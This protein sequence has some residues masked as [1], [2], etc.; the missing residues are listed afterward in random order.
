MITDLSEDLRI[1]LINNRLSNLSRQYFELEMDKAQ[2][3]ANDNAQDIQRVTDRMTQLE[4]AY[5][6]IQALL[7]TTLA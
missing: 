3:Q 1:Q 7:P 5:A 6:A 4:S 2:A